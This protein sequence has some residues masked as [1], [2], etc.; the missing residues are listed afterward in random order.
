MTVE[1]KYP[2]LPSVPYSLRRTRVH[3]RPD[4]PHKV[5]GQPVIL[6]NHA[7]KALRDY[8]KRVEGKGNRS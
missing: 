4:G 5:A 6:V 3:R 1:P 2:R 7:L 8:A